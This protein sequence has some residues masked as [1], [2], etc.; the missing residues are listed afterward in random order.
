[1][2]I[3]FVL[4][5]LGCGGAERV[6]SILANRLIERGFQ[7]EIVCL[8]YNDYYYEVNE[9]VKV[10]FLQDVAA[11]NRKN[12]KVSLDAS[13]SN[14]LVYPG[15]MSLFKRG[16]WLRRYCS[17]QKIDG[18]IA[19]TE[20]VY[21]FVLASLFGTRI[22]VIS[23]ERNDPKFMSWKRNLLKRV[24][25]PTTDWLVVQTEQINRSFNWGGLK[26]KTSIIVNPVREDVFNEGNRRICTK[27]NVIVSVAR[28]FEQKRQE[29]LIEAFSLLVGQFPNW[30]L[31]IYG[32]GPR[33]K[34]LEELILRKKLQNNVFLP[35]TSDSIL[36]VM[37]KAKFFCLSSDY[38]GMS[39][40]MVEAV[41]LGLPIVS[42]KVSGTDELIVVGKNG[43]VVAR[44]DIIGL[45][46]AMKQLMD[47]D[48]K[49]KSFG[50]YSFLLSE[51]FKLEKVIK[52]WERLIT[53]VFV[54]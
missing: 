40:A 45:S 49:V 1:M 20:G 36:L 11:K 2:K 17:E 30:K 37:Q 44:R 43:Y 27:D 53:S 32:E 38:E 16:K 22:K 7:V 23:S 26:S 8:L 41:C 9:K 21:C 19:F 29:I 14:I 35:G 10:T 28:L 42:T 31:Y 34:E 51:K 12:E 13:P 25:L 18:V 52:E 46:V 4:A 3:L 48:E 54:N 39:N 6:V 5:S 24:L 33:R 50:E 15:T 47:D